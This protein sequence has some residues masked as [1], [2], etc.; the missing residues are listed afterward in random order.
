MSNKLQSLN[1]QITDEGGAI[2]YLEREEGNRV[3]AFSDLTKAVERVN[4]TLAGAI[5]E[6]KGTG[7]EDMILHVAEVDPATAVSALDIHGGFHNVTKQ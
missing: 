4:G 1:I 6:Q 3:L 7:L 5:F 2:I